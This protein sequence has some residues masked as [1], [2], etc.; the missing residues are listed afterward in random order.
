MD[1]KSRNGTDK[2]KVQEKQASLQP[3]AGRDISKLRK[4]GR[5]LRQH[6]L[7]GFSLC[8]LA[9]LGLIAIFADFLSP[10]APGVQ[11]EV[12]LSEK[13]EM[14]HRLTG[15]VVTRY[16][17]WVPPSQNIHFFDKMGLHWPYICTLIKEK[18]WPSPSYKEDCAQKYPLR[19]FVHNPNYEYKFFG[20]FN[21]NVHLFGFTD[22]EAPLFGGTSVPEA[23]FF[24][25]GTDK[26]ARDLLSRILYGT[27]AS[28]GISFAAVLMSLLFALPLGGLSGVLGKFSGYFG[29]AMD[30]LIWRM[31]EGVLTF[32]RLALLLI[33]AVLVREQSTRLFWI[34]F[35]LAIFNSV[36]LAQILRGQ[37]LAIGEADYIEAARAQGAGHG[38]VIWRHILPQTVSTIVVSATLAIPNLLMLESFLSYLGLGIEIKPSWGGLLKSIND[39]GPASLPYY[40]WLLFPAVAIFLTVLACTFLGDALRDWFD[41][42][43]QRQAKVG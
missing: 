5:W 18:E 39:V 29:R 15:K 37:V 20:F 27:R 10:Y 8:V 7:G 13:L 1:A 28:L 17:R 31:V 9:F 3:S 41:P 25:L 6:K 42:F 11:N 24:L 26:L 4:F 2:E 35:I 21:L 16:A 33:I 23:R 14:I 43:S 12:Q 30:T 38:R 34:I 22:P 32:P 19:F 40:P 36:S